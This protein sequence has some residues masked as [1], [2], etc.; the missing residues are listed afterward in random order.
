MIYEGKINNPIIII[1]LFVLCYS[2]QVHVPQV[3]RGQGKMII[4]LYDYIL[5]NFSF[6]WVFDKFVSQAVIENIVIE[7]KP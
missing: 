1:F 2:L 7:R 3:L 5:M 6:G 4:V